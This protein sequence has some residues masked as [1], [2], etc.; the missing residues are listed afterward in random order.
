MHNHCLIMQKLKSNQTSALSLEPSAPSHAHL[1]SSQWLFRHSRRRL[2]KSGSSV[3][4]TL[5]KF[6]R[7]LV[8]LGSLFRLSS[9]RS[10]GSVWG[11]KNTYNLT[12]VVYKKKTTFAQIAHHSKSRFFIRLA[13]RCPVYL[14]KTF[15]R[16]C[17]LLSVSLIITVAKLHKIL[18]MAK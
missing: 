12:A 1:I 7:R 2:C 16:W 18:D 6:P 3:A 11:E 5:P 8:R 14:L 15:C 4:R 13:G 17:V 10:A 9:C